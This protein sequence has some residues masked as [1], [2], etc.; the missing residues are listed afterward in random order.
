MFINMEVVLF[1]IFCNHFV[2]STFVTY[3]LVLQ[4]NQVKCASRAQE[5]RVMVLYFR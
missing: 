3:F 5:E 1:T 4:E 2:I